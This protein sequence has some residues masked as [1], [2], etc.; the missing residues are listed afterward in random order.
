MQR[1]RGSQRFA[2]TMQTTHPWALAVGA[3]A[4]AM[5]ASSAAKAAVVVVAGTPER[6][7]GVVVGSGIHPGAQL[8]GNFGS[9]F[10]DT[11]N[12][13]FGARLGFTTGSG[14]YLGGDLEHFIGRDVVGTPHTTFAGGE[15]GLKIFPTYRLEVRPYGFLGA[16]FPSSG[17]TQ[18][19]AAP[20]VVA[21]Y[22][23]GPGFIDV[24]GRYLVT[25]SPATFMLMGGAGIAF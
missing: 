22:H 17:N 1:A 21:A 25:P 10:S 4:C 18:F 16:D 12:L 3:F 9:G 6:E 13:G 11:Y 15:V 14:I 24:D 7:G 8:E 19:A 5:L 2:V 23:F 20:G